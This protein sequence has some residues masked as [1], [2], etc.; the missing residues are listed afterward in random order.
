MDIFLL[1]LRLV[2]T[3]VFG[4]AGIAKA[5]DPQGSMK[6]FAD[7]GVPVVLR[8]PLVYLLPAVEIAIAV[9]LLFK[10]ISWYGAIGAAFLLLVFV[11][12]MLYQ[13]AKGNAPDCH[14]FGQM[15]SEPV[16]VSSILRNIVLLIPAGVL[17][18]MGE[19]SQGYSISTTPQEILTL[20]VGIIL[21]A[22]GLVVILYLQILTQQQRRLMRQLEI[23][24][25]ID[26]HDEIVEREDIGHPREGLPFGALVPNFEAKDLTGKKVTLSDIRADGLP[27]VFIFVGA[28]CA[29]CEALLYDFQEW[30]AEYGGKLKFVYITEGDVE[31]NRKKF[32]HTGRTVILQDMRTRDLS[33]LFRAKW[34]PMAVLMDKRGRIAS[35]T[36]AGD[37][38]IREL[39]GKIEADALQQDHTYYIG[40][41]TQTLTK[42]R[43]GEEMRP[44]VVK[45]INGNEISSNDL[46]GRQTM[47]AFWSPTCKYCGPM[48]EEIKAWDAAKNGVDPGLILFA[49]GESFEQYKEFGLSSPVVWDPD[50]RIGNSIGQFGTPSAIMIDENGRFITETAVGSEDIWALIGKT[51]K[52]DG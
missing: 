37:V 44:F 32:E 35:F 46:R 31:A 34:T 52:T 6:A 33:V 24:E 51:P 15:H 20:S 2:L 9:S 13:F 48:L 17:A 45:D 10:Q 19:Q 36:G 29:V 22:L 21:S 11:G 30:E 39:I 18:L 26:R 42:I 16:G 12:G 47:F 4:I 41:D 43:I 25:L 49:D 28:T 27:V 5:F 3:A 14:C 1:V 40:R 23:M 50:H 7:F 8:R 38:G